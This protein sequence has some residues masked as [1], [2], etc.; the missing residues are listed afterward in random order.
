[1]PRISRTFIS[2]RLIPAIAIEKLIGQFVTLKKSGNNYMGCCPFH[3]E[4]TPSFCVT[5]SKQ[6]FYCFGCKEHGNAIDFLMKYK[7]L[8]FVEACEEACQ[9][10]GIEVEYEAGA[11]PENYDK[12]KQYYELMDRC[13]RQ[14]SQVL[15]SKAGQEGMDY[16]CNKRGLSKNTILQASLGFAP[17]GWHFL[18]E[19]VC[20]NPKEEQ[21]LVDLGMLVRNDKNNVYSMYRN[22]VM[23][24]IFDRKGRIVS[25]GGRTLGDEKPKYMNTKETPIYRKRNELFGLYEALKANNN[26][27]AYFVIVEGYMDVISLR[28]AGSNNAV[29]SLG[30]ATTVEQFKTMFRYSKKIVCCYDGDSAGRNAA[31]HALITA[32]PIL[33]SDYDIRFAFLPKEHDPDSLVREQGLGAFTRILDEAMSYPEFLIAHLSS[34]YDLKDPAAAAAYLAEVL[35]YIRN[36][37]LKPLQ[38][39]ALTLLSSSCGIDERQLYDMLNSK[40]QNNAHSSFI[41]REQSSNYAENKNALTSNILATPMRRLMAFILQQPSLVSSQYHSFGLDGLSA[42]CQKLNVKGAQE[43]ALLLSEFK[44]NPQTNTA[45][46]LER[47]RDTKRERYINLLVNAP[48]GLTLPDGEELSQTAR[49]EYFAH[50]IAMVLVEPLKLRASKLTLNADRLSKAE[51]DEM[52]LLKRELKQIE[53]II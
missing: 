31:W 20:R 3:H 34:N 40:E 14:F 41:N 37:K 15:F 35:S 9:Y 17:E 26:R 44:Q 22:R 42:L 21:M 27:P 4:K 10:A 11:I 33:E 36:I 50:L 43:L 1:M 38:S 48:L 6:M 13:A 28:Q 5:P 18:Q 30:T 52:V 53:A 25:F 23:I 2:E 12:Y 7:N 47:Y 16:F 32:T 49:L 8:G 51:F 46:L 24:P 29:A 19:Q 39:V 45:M